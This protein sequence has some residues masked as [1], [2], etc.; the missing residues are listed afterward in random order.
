MPELAQGLRFD[1]ANPF[2]GHVEFAANLLKRMGASVL[3]TETQTEH[4]TFRCRE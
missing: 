3:Q 1:L 4:L 2:A